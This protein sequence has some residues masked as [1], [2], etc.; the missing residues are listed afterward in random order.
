MLV[1]LA[2]GHSQLMQRIWCGLLVALITILVLAGSGLAATP[3][4]GERDVDGT[5]VF[6]TISGG[7]IYVIKPD[8]TQLRF[9]TTGI[10]PAL[11]P[12]GRQV[13]FTR[14]DNDQRGALGSL[15]LINIDGSNERQILGFLSQPKSPTWSPTAGLEAGD[16]RLA[17]SVQSGGRLQEESKCIGFKGPGLPALPPDAFDIKISVDK[18]GDLSVCFKLPPHPQWG[19]RMI[20]LV[21][22]SFEDLPRDAF[23]YTPTWDPVNDWH[24]VYK[25]DAGLVSLDLNRKVRWALT[26][27]EDD[28]T[29]TFSPDGR[30]IAVS[31]WQHD[32][33]EVHV[34]N[35]DG[36]GRKR[37]TETP[38]RALAEQT[39]KGQ[40]PRAWNNA[41]PAW[42]PDGSRIAFLTDRNGAW[43][44]W[45]MNADGS[46]Q[47]PL[48]P[49]G[50]LAGITLQY[51]GVDERV[52]S[53]R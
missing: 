3:S 35:A 30:M 14:W 37:L 22:G 29:P 6:Q 1:T 31:Y 18:D 21:K 51:Q 27:D 8:G 49:P 39:I 15:W 13:A 43:E 16:P 25:G 33:W 48:F 4:P 19:L 17:I 28:H 53:W 2:K 45:V 36:S 47:R 24:L 32:H 46:Q 11:S 10:D 26:N 38:L 40:E 34:L 20:D 41:A 42:S 50:T 23:S 9:L 12:D 44:I 7:P 52:I 5:I